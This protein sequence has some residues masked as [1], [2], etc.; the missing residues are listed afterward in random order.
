[1]ASS[2]N[3]IFIGKKNTPNY[4]LAVVTQFSMGAKSVTIKARGRA[5]SKA[6]D[7]AELVKKML[8]DVKEKEVKIGSEELGEES[9][10]RTVSVI[11][12]TLTKAK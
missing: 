4:V 8:P 5:I 1:M 10:K 12:I 6:V 7:T 11:E 9:K 2:E 3:V